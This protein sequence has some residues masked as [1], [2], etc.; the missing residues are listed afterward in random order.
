MSVSLVRNSM[1]LLYDPGRTGV[2]VPGDVMVGFGALLSRKWG[3]AWSQRPGFSLINVESGESPAIVVWL[4]S[5]AQTGWAGGPLRGML[6]RTWHPPGPGLRFTDYWI[7]GTQIAHTSLLEVRSPWKMSKKQRWL[8]LWFG[9]SFSA[10]D[11]NLS[12]NP[13]E[14]EA[15]PTRKFQRSGPPACA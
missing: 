6:W 2:A 12:E 15:L 11:L 13:W 14:A 1:L 8:I 9:S 4:L 7:W 3:S 10:V 5:M